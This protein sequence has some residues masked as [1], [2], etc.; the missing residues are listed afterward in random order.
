[1]TLEKVRNIVFWII[2][3]IR[4]GSIKR[5]YIDIKALSENEDGEDTIA[6]QHQYLSELLTHASSTT[7]FYKEIN[8]TDLTNFP[9]IDKEIIKSRYS[10]FQSETYTTKKSVS[11]STSGSTG[12]A[13][14]IHQDFNKKYR[15]TADIIY[16]SELAGFKLGFKLFY[17]RFWTMF[18]QK[19]KLQSFLQ[20]VVPVSVFDLTFKNIEKLI[21][22]LKNDQSNKGMIGYASSFDKIGKYL[23]SIGS[24]PIHCNLK[25]VVGI[26]ERLDLSTKLSIKKY[27]NVDMISRYSNAENGMIAQQPTGKEYFKINWASYYVEIL[28]LNTNQRVQ[29]GELGRI[30]ITD[31]FNYYTPFIRYDT[32]DIGIMDYHTRTESTK[33]QLVLTKV[34]GRKMDMIR[35]TSGELLST[36][37]LLIINK[38]REIEQRQIIQKTKKEYV[39]KLKVKNNSFRKEQVFIKEF[40][41]YLGK[42]A[43]IKIE[44]VTE[45]PLLTSGKQRVI[46]DEAYC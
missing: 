24:E 12:S 43:I 11:V 22:A 42:D 1:M 19:N 20:N 17:L 41:K 18:K 3:F 28:N 4:G 34:E 2:D 33:Q 23:D 44:Y 39:F 6:M 10:D 31:L 38:Y 26:S 27:F 7:N 37:I 35:N 25:S 36:S 29:P 40:E 30:V 13:F 32:G 14:T 45:I 46:I 8:P 16:F 15:N 5:H 21:A 9:V